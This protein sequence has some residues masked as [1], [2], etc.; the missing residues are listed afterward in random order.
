MRA[1]SEC[2][3]GLSALLPIIQRPELIRG[4]LIAR[5]RTASARIKL[6]ETATGNEVLTVK[7]AGIRARRFRPA[8]QW[9]S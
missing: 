1:W 8:W 6:E 5:M 9:R 2:P 3:S 4:L 7:I